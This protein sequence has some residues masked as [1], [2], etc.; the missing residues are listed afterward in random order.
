[1]KK[2][3][4][5]SFLLA[6]PILAGCTLTGKKAASPVPI[7]TAESPLPT[8]TAELNLPDNIPPPPPPPPLTPETIS[9]FD[10]L[11]PDVQDKLREALEN[12]PA[13]SNDAVNSD[14]EPVTQVPSEVNEN[15]APEAS[16]QS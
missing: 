9:G 12:P 15:T 2:Y 3:L 8:T 6:L 5:I 14:T 4:L 1:M 16:S 7:T 10:Q 13:D 11:P